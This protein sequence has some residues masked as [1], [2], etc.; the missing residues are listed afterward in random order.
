MLPG[1]SFV[2]EKN[3]IGVIHNGEFIS[4]TEPADTMSGY[5]ARAFEYIVS[6]NKELVDFFRGRL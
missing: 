2:V 6:N 1:D 4:K 5:K 3:I